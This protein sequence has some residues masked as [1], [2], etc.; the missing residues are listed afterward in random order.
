MPRTLEIVDIVVLCGNTPYCC[1][2]GYVGD[3]EDTADLNR[4]SGRR[5]KM[6]DALV[7]EVVARARVVDVLVRGV[8]ARR[9]PEGNRERACQC[10]PRLGV[11]KTCHGREEVT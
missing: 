11:L 8:V 9:I 10:L 3:D 2:S 1:A 6:S 4:K 5:S 7:L